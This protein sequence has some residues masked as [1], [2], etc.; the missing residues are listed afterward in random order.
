MTTQIWLWGAAG[1]A[2]ALAA[3]AGVAESRRHRRRR[4]DR[5]GWVPWRGLQVTAF[6]AVITFAILAWRTG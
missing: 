4:L 1:A 2:L 3:I 6:F 5:P